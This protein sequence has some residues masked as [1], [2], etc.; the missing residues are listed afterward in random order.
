MP[1]EAG[2]VGRLVTFEEAAR[3]LGGTERSVLIAA[4]N[5]WLRSTEIDEHIRALA[6]E[7]GLQPNP[8][9]PGNHGE[10]I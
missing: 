9:N 6:A 8:T 10:R 7:Q 3:L 4:C 2:F 1:D 5:E